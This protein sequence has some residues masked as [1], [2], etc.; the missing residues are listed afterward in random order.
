MLRQLSKEPLNWILHPFVSCSLLQRHNWFVNSLYQETWHIADKKWRLTHLSMLQSGFIYINTWV[1]GEIS[2]SGWRICWQRQL[3]IVKTDKKALLK[4]SSEVLPQAMPWTQEC[5][6]LIW[7]QNQAF[8]LTC[9]VFLCV[10]KNNS[11]H[12]IPSD[13]WWR[14]HHA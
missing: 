10:R 2:N 11:K 12:C 4:D 6:L 13:T 14:Q 3:L 7:E 8:W 5:A 1:A 9:K